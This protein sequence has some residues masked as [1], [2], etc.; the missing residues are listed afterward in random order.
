[1]SRF[2]PFPPLQAFERLQIADGLLMTAQRWKSAHDYHRQRQN[3]HHQSLHQP[4][5]IC[6]LGVSVIPAPMD[7]AAQYRDG[8]WLQIQPGI[9]IDLLGNPIVVC[10]PESFRIQSEPPPGQSSL[11]YLVVSYVDPDRLRQSA[12][13]ESVRERFRIVEKTDPNDLDVELCRIHLQS[14]EVTLKNPIDVFF[15]GTNELDLRYRQP[16]S[17]RPLG[18]VRVAQMTGGT[19]PENQIASTFSELLEAVA[20]LYPKLHGETE[21]GQIS[22]HSLAN[23]N[24][25][26]YDLLYLPRQHL[27]SLEQPV[28]DTLG[29]YLKGGG[30]LLIAVDFEEVNLD[31]LHGVKHELQV[32]IDNL[33]DEVELLAMRQE[34]EAE[35]SAIDANITQNLQDVGDSIQA[36]AEKMGNPLE[37]LGSLD[38]KHPLRLH[39]FLFAQFPLIKGQPLHLF[40]WGGIILMVGNLAQCWGLDETLTLSRE[41]IR[42]A[43]EMGIN[44]LH[45]AWRRH[46]LTQLQQALPLPATAREQTQTLSQQVPVI[47]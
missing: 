23:T 37:G 21:I 4:G 16:V 44:L 25:S 27:L 17:S 18:I 40:N 33:G 32:A 34:L 45:F 14:G 24:L 1:M 46:Q 7:V 39:P 29:Q 11:V 30:V 12:G 5:I 8:R 3:F 43:Q 6:G 47:E 42:T 19:Q 13:K 26:N 22:S 2:F 10:Q 38:R 20:V 35:I 9:A 28:L 41:T 36:V 15:P 31:E